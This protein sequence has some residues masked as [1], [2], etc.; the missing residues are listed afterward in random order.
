M[1]IGSLDSN[2]ID[3]SIESGKCDLFVASISQFLSK[4]KEIEC[5]QREVVEL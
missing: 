4:S 1:Q 2:E 5:N 3:N